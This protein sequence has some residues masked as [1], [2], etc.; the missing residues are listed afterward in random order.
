MDMITVRTQAPRCGLV[1]LYLFCY[2]TVTL[3]IKHFVMYFY[4]LTLLILILFV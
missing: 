3:F 1:L 4:K 2:F